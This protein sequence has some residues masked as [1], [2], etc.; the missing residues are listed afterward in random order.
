MIDDEFLKQYININY[1]KWYQAIQS[2]IDSAMDEG[3]FIYLG[4][5]AK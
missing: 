2:A 3:S 4:E 1:D 5:A